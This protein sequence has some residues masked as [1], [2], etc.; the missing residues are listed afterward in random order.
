MIQSILLQNFQSHKKTSLEL[1]QGINCIIGPSNNGKTSILRGLYW[2]LYNRPSGDS[3]IAHWN[4]NKNDKPIKSTFVRIT[5]DK[6]I[7]ER[8]KGYIKCDD[9]LVDFN[10][11]IVNENELEA[12]G[13]SVPD[14]VTNLFNL[15]SV[16]IQRQTDAPFLLSESAGEVARFFNSTIRLDQIDSA[17]T[18]AESKRRDTNKEKI[19]LENELSQIAKDIETFNW[20]EQAEIIAN[21]IVKIENRIVDNENKYERLSSLYEE[22]VESVA[23]ISSQE[24]ILSAVPIVNK[25]VCMQ[26][27]LEQKI[28]KYERLQNLYEQYIEQN[29]II[30]GTAD[31]SL[32]YELINKIEKL[33]DVI[34]GKEKLKDRLEGMIWEYNIKD[35]EQKTCNENII[36][37][38]MLLPDLCPLCGNAI[39]G[40]KCK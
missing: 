10:G 14:E 3:Y 16:N 31:F 20:L 23:I 38:E 25:I 18:K 39:K 36:K 1:H 15:D 7:I 22:Y 27:S 32:A 12:I 17:L 40:D 30:E 37:L 24:V 11:Y 5:T 34:K 8:R 2:D 26:E 13:Q 19:R 6:G 4:R 29:T 9:K 33:D 35:E 21:K 28:E